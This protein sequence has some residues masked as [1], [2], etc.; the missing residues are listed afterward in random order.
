[1][2]KIMRQKAIIN[3]ITTE[4]VSTQQELKEKL[5]ENGFEATQATISR[6]IKELSLIKT[7]SIDGVYKYDIPN[8]IKDKGKSP[9]ELLISIFNEAVISVNFAGNIVVI[10]CHTGMAQA[11]CAKLDS[12][13]FDSI[14]GTLAG[15]DTIFVVLKSESFAI[16]FTGV[17][18]K[19]LS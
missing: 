15:D 1:M 13:N 3:I 16:E 2:S 19:F 6:D 4:N 9:G 10:K 14:V 11:V 18:N 5:S 7:V 12:A 8:S 17:L